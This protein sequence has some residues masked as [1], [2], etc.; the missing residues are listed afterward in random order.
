[1]KLFLSAASIVALLAGSASAEDAAT[2]DIWQ[3]TEASKS[4]IAIA[5]VGD[6]APFAAAAGADKSA[7]DL[8]AADEASVAVAEFRA[9]TTEEV[10]V[11]E[12]AVEA[13]AETKGEKKIVEIVKEEKVEDQSAHSPKDH[14]EAAEAKTADSPHKIVLVKASAED[15]DCMPEKK[16]VRRFIK[17]NSDKGMT[18][19]DLAALIEKAQADLKAEGG[20]IA[21]EHGPLAANDMDAAVLASAKK[22]VV[23][24]NAKDGASTRLVAISGASADA[25]R[26]FIA[27]AEGLDDAEK[28]KIKTDL[29]L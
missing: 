26:D 23:V 5:A 22:V 25:A 20:E 4:V 17:L 24:E 27:K 8:L 16:E 13:G 3:S 28:T 21:V 9:R 18:D 12:N 14:A 2:Y 19:A 1:M 7:L 15:K 11:A 29:G 6:K 10:D